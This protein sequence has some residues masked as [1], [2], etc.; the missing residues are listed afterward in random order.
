MVRGSVFFLNPGRS[1]SRKGTK[2]ERATTHGKEGPTMFAKMV[3]IRAAD[4]SLKTLELGIP[5][6]GKEGQILI[7]RSDKDGDVG[8]ADPPGKEVG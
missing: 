6:G 7:K 3:A 5:D 1:A 4:G 2:R 8:W